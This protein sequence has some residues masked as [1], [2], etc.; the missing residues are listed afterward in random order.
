MGTQDFSSFD[1][2][3]ELVIEEDGL[4]TVLGVALRDAAGW[5]RMT[6]GTV[7]Y[8]EDELKQRALGCFPPLSADR[9]A[10]FRIYKKGLPLGNLIEAVLEPTDSGDKLL[11][12]SASG[13]AAEILRKIERLVCTR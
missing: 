7:A 3:D 4:V 1:E 10:E 8:I 2:L 13:A 9:N 11:R 6:E 5:A 12:E